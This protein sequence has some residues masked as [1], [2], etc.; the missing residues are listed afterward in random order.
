[1]VFILFRL[2]F[3]LEVSLISAWESCG[4]KE[5]GKGVLIGLKLATICKKLSR[6]LV[7]YMQLVHAETSSCMRLVRAAKTASLC[8]FLYVACSCALSIV[9]A[10]TSTS[11]CMRLWDV[12]TLNVLLHVRN[13]PA[14]TGTPSC[15]HR[16][17]HMW[18][19]R[20]NCVACAIHRSCDILIPG[21]VKWHL[22]TEHI[23]VRKNKQ[24]HIYSEKYH[25]LQKF[26]FQNLYLRSRR[27]LPKYIYT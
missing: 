9:L 15:S 4:N 16:W 23:Q 17:L 11:C 3:C 14:C 24:I 1:M 12:Y 18:K 22:I 21:G 13:D 10:R 26:E 7:V 19:R 8:A 27:W 5:K 25:P 20:V 2:Q 6:K